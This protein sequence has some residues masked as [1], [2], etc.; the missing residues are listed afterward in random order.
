MSTRTPNSP[1]PSAVAV[2]LLAG[3]VS[4]AAC[5][6]ST[7]S[8]EPRTSERAEVAVPPPLFD[9]RGRPLAAPPTAVPADAAARTRPGLYAT[10]AQ[11]EREALTSGPTTILLDVDALGTTQMTVLLAQQVRGYREGQRLTYFVQA[12]RPADAAEVVNTLADDGFAPVFVI[13]R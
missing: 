3:A 9:E 13:V 7:A 4:V 8:N 5:G 6:G 10:R 1:T 11:Y 2:L 12:R